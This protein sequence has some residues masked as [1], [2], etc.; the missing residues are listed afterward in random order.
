MIYL[1]L[2][3]NVIDAKLSSN[4]NQTKNDEN[5]VLK[6]SL[7][8]LCMTVEHF[9]PVP[10]QNSSYYECATLTENERKDYGIDG[11]YLGLWTKRCGF[12]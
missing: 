2:V 9:R 11:K 8:G 3:L 1:F 5:G 7:G 10:D 4:Y 6:T 12:N